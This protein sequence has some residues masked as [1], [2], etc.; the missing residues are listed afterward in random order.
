MSATLNTRALTLSGAVA[1]VG[2]P[3]GCLVA[4]VCNRLTKPARLA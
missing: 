3:L 4:L 2:A 1:G